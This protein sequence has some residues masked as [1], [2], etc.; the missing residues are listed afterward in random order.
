MTGPR[1]PLEDLHHVALLA[2]LPSQCR[3]DHILQTIKG[4][5]AERLANGR[6]IGDKGGRVTRPTLGSRD[7]QFS[8]L[9]LLNGANHL[10]NRMAVT[11]TAVEA[12]VAAGPA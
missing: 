9:G 4:A 5:P 3:A 11:V 10:Q 1:R 7:M 6:R 8:P 12:G 2:T